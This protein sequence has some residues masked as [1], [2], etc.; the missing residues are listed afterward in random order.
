MRTLGS[1]RPL[2]RRPIPS[3]HVLDSFLRGVDAALRDD[4]GGLAGLRGRGVHAGARVL[5]VVV[6]GIMDQVARGRRTL[7]VHVAHASSPCR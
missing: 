7:A 1:R 6:V 3:T 4:G 5:L 2:G